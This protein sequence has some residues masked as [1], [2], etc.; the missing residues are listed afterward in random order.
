MKKIFIA[1][2]AVFMVVVVAVLA[3]LNVKKKNIGVAF[4]SPTAIR[5]YNN[6]T[7]P[8]NSKGFSKDDNEYSEIIDL[9]DDMTNIS[10]FNR[11]LDLKTLN[12][13]IEISNDETYVS[14]SSDL[15]NGNYVIELDFNEEQDLVVYENGYTRV[16]SYFCILY[17]I[18]KDE[19]MSDIIVYYSNTND[20]QTRDE[21][22]AR[23]NPFVL[24]G[25]VS[26]ITDYIDAMS[27]AK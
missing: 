5:I 4:G 22:Y 15:K 21:S 18:S 27:S 9:I 23:N 8:I 10:Y 17:V 24:K 13:K 14:Y 26:E 25:Y 12:T 6:S 7:S 11:L 2:S 1:I 20:S 16:I 19:S 3:T